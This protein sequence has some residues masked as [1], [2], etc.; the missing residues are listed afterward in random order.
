MLY[1]PLAVRRLF[2]VNS[3]PHTGA[4]PSVRLCVGL[5]NRRCGTHRR[6]FRGA[7]RSP[8]ICRP[9]GQGTP[10]QPRERRPGGPR[11]Q[12]GRVSEE[13]QGGGEEEDEEDEE[14]EEEEEE[15]EEGEAEGDEQRG[16]ATHGPRCMDPAG[17]ATQSYCPAFTQ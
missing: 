17:L 7:S 12:Q 2:E 13:K 16:A 15:K 1:P 9:L 8:S 3:E 10:H 11:W 6:V 4:R 5:I 14:D